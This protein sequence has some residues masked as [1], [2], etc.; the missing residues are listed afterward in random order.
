MV[1]I[2]FHD[3]SNSKREREGERKTKKEKGKKG[4]K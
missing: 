4:E 3:A 2:L 1:S